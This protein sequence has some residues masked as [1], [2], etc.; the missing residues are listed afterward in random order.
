MQDLVALRIRDFRQGMRLDFVLQTSAY[1]CHAMDMADDPDRTCALPLSSPPS[2]CGCMLSRPLCT[3]IRREHA[4]IYDEQ[5]RWSS[6]F[7]PQKFS[8]T[9]RKPTALGATNSDRLST[10][11]FPSTVSIL[12]S[13]HTFRALLPL[14]S[15]GRASSGTALAL[16]T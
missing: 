14:S 5:L 9:G 7:R 4:F 10:Q 2:D 6:S 16:T 11:T 1:A 8:G 12:A 13:T 15:G 3:I